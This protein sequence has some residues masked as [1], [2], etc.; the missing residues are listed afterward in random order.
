MRNGHDWHIMHL[1][2]RVTLIFV[3]D[4]YDQGGSEGPWIYFTLECYCLVFYS[5]YISVLLVRKAVV[6]VI[7]IKAGGVLNIN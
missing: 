6:K 1:G 2:H 3:N 5:R 7:W 4:F